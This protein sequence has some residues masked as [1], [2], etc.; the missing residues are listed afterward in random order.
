MHRSLFGKRRSSW[1][2]LRKRLG[3]YPCTISAVQPPLPVLRYCGFYDCYAPQR[4]IVHV[5]R[6]TGTS[7]STTT[8]VTSPAF[9]GLGCR[10]RIGRLD[11]KVA[12]AQIN[13]TI[14]DFAGNLAKMVDSRERAVAAGAQL[15]I[16]PE[17]CIVGYPAQDLIERDAFIRQ[18]LDALIQFA[19]NC[20][21]IAAIVGYI[22]PHTG[23]GKRRYNAAAFIRNGRVLSKHFKTLLPT[24]DVFDEWRHFD[25]APSIQPI[26]FDLHRLGITI[27]EDIWNDPDF[28][29]IR[30][31]A[32][33]PA[34]ELCTSGAD[35]L[36]NIAASP[37]TLEKRRLRPAML[38]ATAVN[39]RCPVIFVNQVG[40]NDELIFDGRSAVY[41]ADG[42]LLAEAPEFEEALL[43]VDLSAPSVQ[44]PSK[45]IDDTSTVLKAL[46]LGTRDYLHKCGFQQCVLGLSGGV[47]SSV[48]AAIAARAIGAENVFGV[49]M[50]S[51]YSSAESLEDA[52]ALAENLGIRFKQIDID[53]IFSVVLGALAPTFHGLS[54]DITEENLQARIRGLLLMAFSNKFG[55]LVLTT[56]N[57]SE[58]ATGYCTLYGDM[59]G[60]LAI[61]ADI[62]KTL[63]YRLAATINRDAP[64]IPQRVFDKAPSAELR[65]AQIDQDTLPPYDELDRILLHHIEHGQDAKD[66]AE[67]GFPLKLTD[68]LLRMVRMSEYKR[69]QAA[70]GLKITSKAFGYG[71]RFPIA[72]KWPG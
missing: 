62:P 25:P 13:P 45:S 60:G 10:C 30:R 36:I 34:K 40:G 26:D 28:W 47:D 41:A 27:C 37:F 46:T 32:S 42:T 64:I 69:R 51:R 38:K 54:T 23:D 39:R 1:T 21:A 7:Q 29:S 9:R 31:Y 14:G 12:L 44:P 71:R 49:A 8:D 20:T 18:N 55:A 63:V 17:C 19:A 50:P 15:I 66:L 2:I 52:S 72:Q 11:V 24:Y 67:V 3:A 68:Q 5:D 59:V 56:G 70:P 33:D 58:L 22:E 16:F 48:V 35:L 65:P 43:V 6:S 61:I 53:P 57:K 4:L